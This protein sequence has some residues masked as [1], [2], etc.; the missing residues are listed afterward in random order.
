MC[1]ISPQVSD[2]KNCY[3]V[4]GDFQRST[5]DFD[6][7]QWY[8]GFPLT[9]SLALATHMLLLVCDSSG[10]PNPF[11]ECCLRYGLT[12]LAVILGAD[13]V[14]ARILPGITIRLQADNQFYSVEDVQV[15]VCVLA[16]LFF[17]P[18]LYLFRYT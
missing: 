6:I 15:C 17:C 16:S 3:L 4:R 7:S 13:K 1:V 14:W 9:R 10:D 18:F 8:A 11:V 2:K 12:C 5:E